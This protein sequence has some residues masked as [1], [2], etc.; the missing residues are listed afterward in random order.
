[1][2]RMIGELIFQFHKGAIRTIFRCFS[3]YASY[4]FNS[5]KV[6]LEL[7]STVSNRYVRIFQFHKGAIRTVSPIVGAGL[8][9]LFQCKYSVLPHI[10]DKHMRFSPPPANTRGGYTLI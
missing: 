1:M 6:R 3:F 5:I 2:I 7:A 9:L 10:T 4:Y 8:S